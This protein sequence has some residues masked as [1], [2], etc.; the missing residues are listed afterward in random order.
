MNTE[1]PP[2]V[3]FRIASPIR[4][5]TSL[6]DAAQKG[7]RYALLK[8]AEELHDP[9]YR[10]LGRL[11]PSHSED[12][13]EDVAQDAFIRILGNLSRF[14]PQGTASF[15]T[16]AVTIAMRVGLDSIRK[17]RRNLLREVSMVDT[18]SMDPQ[19]GPESIAASHQVARQVEVAM[20][21]LT[22]E[23]RSVLI[24]RACHGL[25]YAEIAEAL[26]IEPPAVRSRLQRA[27]AA[28][29]QVLGTKGRTR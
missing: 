3:S 12:V 15:T 7:Q 16:W 1:T 22:P 4:T 17:R 14:D 21:G 23:Q 28:L 18:E 13:V 2:L 25:T 9:V 29:R 20:D 6:I 11:F 24:L 27:R 19:P 5:E 8:L 10:A 26:A